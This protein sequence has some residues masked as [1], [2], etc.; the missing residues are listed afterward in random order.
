M[1]IPRRQWPRGYE[2]LALFVLQRATSEDCDFS[3]KTTDP[4]LIDAC[5]DVSAAV[6]ADPL[7]GANHAPTAKRDRPHIEHGVLLDAEVVQ[8]A[9]DSREL[10]TVV[11]V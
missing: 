5:E 3:R 10:D 2:V 6:Q 7:I 4:C 1:T 8:E 9:R 11:L